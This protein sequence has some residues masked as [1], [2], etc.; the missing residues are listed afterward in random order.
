VVSYNSSCHTNDKENA[1]PETTNDQQQILDLIAQW[2]AALEAKDVERLLRDYAPD[3]LSF[4]A[5]PPYKLE[6]IDSVK[7]AWT[8][9]LPYFPDTFRSEH[10]D[11]K[12]HVSGDVA[13]VHG[14]HRF[15][16]EP[17][18][19]PCGQSWLRVTVGLQRMDGVWKVVHE[20]LSIPFNPMTDQTWP[21]TDP[22]LP[23]MPDYTQGGAE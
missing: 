9:C 8:S 18:D 23:D 19:H 10:R 15:V 3:V 16:P 11:L 13:F 22:D 7:N 21:I 2:R 12:V 5:I 1:M 4:D 17:P 14:L 6:G 20:H